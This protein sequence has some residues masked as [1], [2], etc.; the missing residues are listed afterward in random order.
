MKNGCNVNF[1]INKL[2]LKGDKCNKWRII[3]KGIFIYF[4]KSKFKTVGFEHLLELE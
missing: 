2:F 4:N 1:L 3:P